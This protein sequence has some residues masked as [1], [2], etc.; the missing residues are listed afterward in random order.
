LIINLLYL[1][2]FTFYSIFIHSH[3][4]ISSSL[5]RR[6]HIVII[7][8]CKWWLG[9]I[10][11]EWWGA[12]TLNKRINFFS[13]TKRMEFIIRG[14]ICFYIINAE[15]IYVG[16]LGLFKGMRMIYKLR[17]RVKAWRGSILFWCDFL[18]CNRAQIYKHWVR[19]ICYV[20]EYMKTFLIHICLIL[21]F[22]SFLWRILIFILESIF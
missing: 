17:R 13:L 6:H 15:F 11:T 5:K 18:L 4:F 21:I 12:F 3:V 14:Y 20:L 1:R 7:I 22:Q 16:R 8:D 10:I 9:S 19:K 2:I